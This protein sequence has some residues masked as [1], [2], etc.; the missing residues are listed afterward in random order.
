MKRLTH[1]VLLL[2]PLVCQAALAAPPTNACH[3]PVVRTL[4]SGQ[5]AVIA[6]G[7]FEACSTGSYSVRLYEAAPEADRT[8]F[9]QDGI[10]VA[11]SGDI[12]RVVLADIEGKGNEDIVVVVR[13][14]GTGNY[15]SARAFAYDRHNLSLIAQVEDLPANGDPLAA[16]RQAIKPPPVPNGSDDGQGAVH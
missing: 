4:A 12:A 8:T 2:L 9:F 14:V 7:E 3:P 5:T 16:L 15:L 13:S 1:C 11:R 10:V 6:E